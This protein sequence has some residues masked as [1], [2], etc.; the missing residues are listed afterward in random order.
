MPRFS[1]LYRSDWNPLL[2]YRL[3]WPLVGIGLV[4]LVANANLVIDAS[5]TGWEFLWPSMT[6]RMAESEQPGQ[7]NVSQWMLN[8]TW[9]LAWIGTV[10]A[11]C[12]GVVA[13]RIVYS[14]R[15]SGWSQQ[16]V[17][18][19]AIAIASLMMFLLLLHNAFDLSAIVCTNQPSLPPGVMRC[20]SLR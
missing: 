6:R 2:L 10:W 18:T 20:R 5:I 8:S 17:K 15:Q 14:P 3:F 1:R 19:L 11:A 13:M 12:L 4:V 7:V 9:L 16:R